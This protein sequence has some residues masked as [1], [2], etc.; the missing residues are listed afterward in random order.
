MSF[1]QYDRMLQERMLQE[2]RVANWLAAEAQVN[3]HL[4]KTSE[5]NMLVQTR[6]DNAYEAVR[7]MVGMS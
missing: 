2:L 7:T 4:H 6:I 3:L 1:N 5:H